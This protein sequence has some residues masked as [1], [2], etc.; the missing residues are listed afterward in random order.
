MDVLDQPIG[1]VR[2]RFAAQIVGVPL[3]DVLKAREDVHDRFRLAGLVERL[4]AE[5]R[6]HAARALGDVQVEGT[7]AKLLG[8]DQICEL[9]LLLDVLELPV[10]VDQEERNGGKALLAVDD[11]LL[12]VFVADDDGTEEVVAVVLDSAA[13]VPG[14]VAVKKLLREVIDQF[15]NLLALPA[16]LALVVVDRELG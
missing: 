3:L 2:Q 11:E 10:E 15:G 4:A 13:L 6:L 8:E 9:S 7:L 14:L 5:E 12:P 1:E 16:V